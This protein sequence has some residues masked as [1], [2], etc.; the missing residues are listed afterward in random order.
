[1]DNRHVCAEGELDLAKHPFEP[2]EYG[3][4]GALM[5]VGVIGVWHFMLCV[6]H[7]RLDVIM[8]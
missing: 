5:L 1:M 8:C 7:P 2:I 6:M 4:G 3:S